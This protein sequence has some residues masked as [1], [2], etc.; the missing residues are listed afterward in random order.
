MW[1]RLFIAMSILPV[2]RA[3]LI[4]RTAIVVGRVPILDSEIDR[5]VRITA[6]LNHQAPDFGLPSRKQA[7]SRLIDQELIRQQIRLG[8]FPIA[9][10]QETDKLLEQI[11]HDRG[12]QFKPSLEQYGITRTELRDRLSWQLTVLRFIDTMFRPQ[13]IVSDPDIEKYYESHRTQF[14]SQPLSAARPVIEDTI[15]GERINGLF[16]NWLEQSRKSAR[17]VYLEKSL[18]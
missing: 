15:S 6:F 12:A 13:V 1:L 17:I 3:V 9:S 2:A 8:S 7:A 16:D 4:D 5:D 11:E 10:H 18:A 14:G